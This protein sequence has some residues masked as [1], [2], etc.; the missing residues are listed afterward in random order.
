MLYEVWLQLRH[1][2]RPSVSSTTNK[3]LGLTHNLGGLPGEMVSF[4]ALRCRAGSTPVTDL[5]LGPK[6]PRCEA[7]VARV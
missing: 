1:E 7:P 6:E 2:P 4:V 5:R 3:N